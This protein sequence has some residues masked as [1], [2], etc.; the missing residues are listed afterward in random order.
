MKLYSFLVI[1]CV[2]CFSSLQAMP[3]AYAQ[4]QTGAGGLD[5]IK[6]LL[7]RPAGWKVDHIGPSGSGQSEFI[8][9][10][11]GEKVVVRIQNLSRSDGGI[12]LN[13]ERDV[14]I[15]SD[16]I[17]HDGCRDGGITLRFD[18]NDQD[19]PLKGKSLLNYEYKFRAK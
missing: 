17:K 3:T 15:T 18:P 1:S 10:A 19:Y 16:G 8:Y 4:D 11:R 9:E 12:L 7:L 2:L 6:A 5:K 14:T 13:C